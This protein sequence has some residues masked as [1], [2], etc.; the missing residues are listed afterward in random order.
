[1]AEAYPRRFNERDADY[2]VRLNNVNVLVNGQPLTLEQISSL[3]ELPLELVPVALA[4]PSRSEETHAEY[5]VR[6]HYYSQKDQPEA[7]VNGQPL[8]PE[9]ISSLSG[10]PL[11]WVPGALAHLRMPDETNADD[12]VR[13]NRASQENFPDARVNPRPLTVAE[14]SPRSSEAAGSLT[15]ARSQVSRRTARNEPELD[16]ELDPVAKDFRKKSGEQ[17]MQ[18]AVRMHL[19]SQLKEDKA[20]VDGQPLTL[21]QISSLSK[22]PLDDLRR[23]CRFQPMSAGLV[24]VRQ[25]FP[26]EKTEWPAGYVKRLQWTSENDPNACVNGQPLNAEQLSQLSGVP[27]ADVLKILDSNEKFTLTC[28][29]TDNKNNWESDVKGISWRKENKSWTV[30]LNGVQPRSFN[31]EGGKDPGHV[32]AAHEEA[33]AHIKSHGVTVVKK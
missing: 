10:L 13:P 12:A 14:P 8:T 3:S 32:E 20:L 17:P 29:R 15:R 31:T 7:R 22:V 21:E 27:K 18:H 9:Q 26:P 2:A 24:R 33:I 4:F 5:A 30:H 19:A 16:L 6:L 28:R 25:A 1:V 11:K 23:D